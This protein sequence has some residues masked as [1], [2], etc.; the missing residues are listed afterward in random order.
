MDE[1]KTL[2]KNSNS[3]QKLCKFIVE[4]HI[5]WLLLLDVVF[6]GCATSWNQVS[7]NLIWRVHELS[8]TQKDIQ[9]FMHIYAEIIYIVRIFLS[10]LGRQLIFWY[11]NI[12]YTQ[13]FMNWG[14]FLVKV[15]YA[16][17]SL[18]EWHLLFFAWFVQHV[19]CSTCNL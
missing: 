13:Q 1:Y 12:G 18:F 4:G 10:L 5:P 11:M 15:L 9:L 19:P 8:F 6:S 3:C 2:I 16:S 14:Y 17:L 7:L